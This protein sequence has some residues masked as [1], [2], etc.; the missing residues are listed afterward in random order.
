M[1][2]SDLEAEEANGIDDVVFSVGPGGRQDR[3]EVLDPQREEEQEAQE[4]APDVHR[5]IGQDKN[6]TERRRGNGAGR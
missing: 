5:L 1:R 4:V 6:T 3:G 2:D